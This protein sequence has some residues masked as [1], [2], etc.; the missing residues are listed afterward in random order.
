MQP[1]FVQSECQAIESVEQLV[2]SKAQCAL[3]AT[4]QSSVVNAILLLLAEALVFSGVFSL[5]TKKYYSYNFQYNQALLR[6]TPYKEKQ[7]R[8]SRDDIL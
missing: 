5:I 1:G 7:R 6:N 2:V 3:G 8:F 4:R